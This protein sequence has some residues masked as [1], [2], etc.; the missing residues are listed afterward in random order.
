MKMGDKTLLGEA[1][2]CKC[3]FFIMIFNLSFD[4]VRKVDRSKIKVPRSGTLCT[5]RYLTCE[6]QELFLFIKRYTFKS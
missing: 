6:T 3:I 1:L 4:A 5:F 2:P